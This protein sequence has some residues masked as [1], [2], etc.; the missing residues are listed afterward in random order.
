MS[1]NKSY[2]KFIKWFFVAAAV[3]TLVYFY[4]LGG[5]NDI[6][7]KLEVNQNEFKN[8]DKIEVSLLFHARSRTRLYINDNLP[9]TI[10]IIIDPEDRK[11]C[12]AR[13]R[14]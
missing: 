11:E 7:L 13:T 1:V 2:P 3:C 14:I 8:G 10:S 4:L 5:K 6:D 9:E 12:E